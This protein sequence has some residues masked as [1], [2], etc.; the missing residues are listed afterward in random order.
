MPTAAETVHRPLLS[1]FQAADYLGVPRQ[2]LA[3]WRTRHSRTG[4]AWV[5]IGRHVKYRPADLDAWIDAQ[6]VT[7]GPRP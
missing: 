3:V 2:T 4:P 5:K 1:T 7:P 6:T